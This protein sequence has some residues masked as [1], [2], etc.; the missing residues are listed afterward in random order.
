MAKLTRT[1]IDFQAVQNMIYLMYEGTTDPTITGSL[2]NVFSYKGLK[3]N[4]FIT[5]SFGNVIRLDPVFSNQYTDLDA[6]PK[7]FKNRWMR[8]G[9]EHR[10]NI[11]ADYL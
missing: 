3:L 6:M 7:E 4:V 10:T 2:G 5:Y 11:P 1:N 8:P 9:D